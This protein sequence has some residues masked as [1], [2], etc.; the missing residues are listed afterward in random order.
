M[1]FYFYVRQIWGGICHANRKDFH[2][3]HRGAMEDQSPGGKGHGRPS[4][5]DANPP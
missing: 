2:P 3:S 5:Q 4:L 1:F